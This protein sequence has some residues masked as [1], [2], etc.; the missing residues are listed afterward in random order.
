MSARLVPEAVLKASPGTSSSHQD[1]VRQTFANGSFHGL[2]GAATHGHRPLG[3]CTDF[4]PQARALDFAPG[5]L[6]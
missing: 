1:A 2:V 6:I 3:V 5:Y 4:E